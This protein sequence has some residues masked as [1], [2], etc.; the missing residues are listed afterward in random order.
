[1][2]YLVHVLV[3]IAIYA[4]LAISLN[5]AAGYTGLLSLAHAA[6]YGV[7]AYSVALLTVRL[8]TS[9][10]LALAAGALAAGLLGAVVALP[11]LRL[12]DDYFVLAT[13]AFQIIVFSILN[14]WLA[15]TG[16]P[17]GVAGIPRPSLAGFRIA[18]RA[19]FLP[20]VLIVALAVAV[21]AYRLGAAPFG[22]VLKAIREDEI[23]AQALGKNVVA[24]KIIVLVVGAGMAAVAGG[25]Y[26][27]YVSFVDPS[28]FTVLESIF[29]LS[30]VIVGGA[31]SFWGP[32]VGAALLVAMPEGLRF[33]G[34]P[35][36]WA[37]NL[38]E[39]LYGVLLVAFMLWRPQGILGLY[40]FTRS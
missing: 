28:S 9:F 7:G 39:I 32:I 30:L 20:L 4:I 21:I 5:L 23:V 11:S 19:D 26:A 18:S 17:L 6:F 16:G 34:F 24:Y 22:R 2:D 29:I 38:R 27:A 3:L 15:V 33:L 37:A 31:G 8:D 13:F 12:H 10:L 1:M 14:N 36:A 35:I 25:L 40:R